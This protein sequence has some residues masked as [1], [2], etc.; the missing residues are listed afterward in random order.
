MASSVP[1]KRKVTEEARVFQNKW[2]EDYFFIE[3]QQKAICLICQESVAVMKAYN[4]K[5]HYDSKHS[6]KFDIIK[7]QF[8]VDKIE[9]LKKNIQSQQLNLLTTVVHARNIVTWLPR[10]K[11]RYA[12]SHT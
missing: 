12:K 10:S 1:K 4:L 2:T 5:R 8:R 11:I 3:T 7:G 9:T 6:S